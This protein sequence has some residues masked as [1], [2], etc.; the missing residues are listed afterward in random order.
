MEINT[1]V[2]D[3]LK[4]KQHFK[5]SSPA[6]SEALSIINKT[7]AILNIIVNDIEML[8]FQ[9]P[10]FNIE[11]FLSTTDNLLTNGPAG[12][13]VLPHSD[14]ASAP[15]PGYASGASMG[16]VPNRR[17]YDLFGHAEPDLG[18]DPCPYGW[19]KFR[20][21]C[22]LLSSD[23]KPWVNAAVCIIWVEGFKK[24][25]GGQGTPSFFF[26]LPFIL[27]FFTC[28]IFLEWVFPSSSPFGQPL[29]TFTFTKAIRRACYC[30]AG[31]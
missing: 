3:T 9:K 1:C 13:D 27:F 19:F 30:R 15:G 10:Y 2:S 11:S 18:T 26:K 7:C 6:M 31:S 29:N 28:W 4:T 23:T 20:D 17:E 22:Y 8:Q 21:S 14:P 5:I 16:A 12:S 24:K 25:G